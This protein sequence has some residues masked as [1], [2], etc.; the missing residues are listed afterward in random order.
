MAGLNG[1]R[2][3]SSV[4]LENISAFGR[5]S[6]R[7]PP[8]IVVIEGEEAT[9]EVGYL[10]AER[11]IGQDAARLHLGEKRLRGKEVAANLKPA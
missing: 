11:G 2:P 6:V 1:S 3:R 8:P 5:R 9:I 10:A 7:F 4:A